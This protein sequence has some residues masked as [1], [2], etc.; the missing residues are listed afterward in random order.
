ML[1]T[2]TIWAT[3]DAHIVRE[4]LA[5]GIDPARVPRESMT[6]AIE[7]AQ[8]PDGFDFDIA[9]HLGDILDYDH[10]TA[11]NFQQFRNQLAHCHKDAHYWYH[12]GGN[13]DENSVLN[14]GVAIDNE[15]YRKVIDPVGEFTELSGI[16]NRKRPYPT[17]GTY[18]RYHVDVGNIRMLFLSDRNDLPAPYGRGEGGFYVDGAITLESYLWLL[19]QVITW[20]ERIL[21]VVCHHAL[22]DTTIGTSIDDSWTGQYMTFYSPDKAPSNTNRLQGTLHQVYPI[23][24]FDTP[25]FHN[26]LSQ[27]PGVV[28]VWLSGHVHHQVDETYR[29]R[30]K[31]SHAYGGHHLN[32]A[33]LC[34]YRH[35][36]NIISA[37]S[38]VLTVKAGDDRLH[39]Q[40]YVHDHPTLPSGFYPP[41]DR[42]LQL[43]ATVSSKPPHVDVTPPETGAHDVTTQRVG[44]GY[45]RLMWSADS[46]GTLLIRSDSST[47]AFAPK[48]GEIYYVGQVL[49]AEEGVVVHM[50]TG[51][52]LTPVA[53]GEG[54]VYFHFFTYNAGQGHIIYQRSAATVF[55]L[56]SK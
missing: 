56:P 33:N 31:Y 16:D 18:E 10:E 48:D 25:L 28:D 30:G 45:V 6:C 17:V 34:R 1:D 55:P 49:D 50:G 2:F 8:G 21:M 42:Q 29:G 27:N 37:Q 51:R 26:L 23:H 44:G 41:E 14:D 36:A 32:V 19:G 52:S 43:K 38:N 4:L 7:Q 22:K 53:Q 46:V 20:P 24:D 35:M 15:H 12:V 9:L 3:S 11:D 39:S 54:N 13:N 47:L 5:E 40:V